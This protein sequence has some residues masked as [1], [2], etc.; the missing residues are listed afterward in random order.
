MENSTEASVPDKQ[1][2]RCS[3]CGGGDF[4][5]LLS[6]KYRCKYC[7]TEQ[8]P[9]AIQTHTVDASTPFFDGNIF[10]KHPLFFGAAAFFLIAL[11]YLGITYA[12]AQSV[13]GE[14]STAYQ[15]V[16]VQKERS[17]SILTRNKTLLAKQ[18]AIDVTRVSLEDAVSTL[19]VANDAAAQRI[20]DDL[21]GSL[22]RET[23][24]LR[25][26]KIAHEN[27]TA[28]GNWL[29]QSLGKK[30]ILKD[31]AEKKLIQQK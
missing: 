6:G 18:F 5:L 2:T 14:L 28:N 10:K 24:A 26:Y 3:N 21:A 31:A 15:E 27:F 29:A 23:V 12:S 8:L 11:I 20:L 25:R 13:V 7:G 9:L 19:T 4:D 30:Y 17:Q 16:I 1:M 22:N